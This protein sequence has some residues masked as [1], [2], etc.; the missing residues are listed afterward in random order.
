MSA[1]VSLVGEEIVYFL[2]CPNGLIYVGQTDD[3]AKRRKAHLKGHNSPLAFMP[4]NKD[5][6]RRIHDAFASHRVLREGC[7]S[8]FES[9]ALIPYLERLL[10]R[11]FA[12]LDV[13]D[14]ATMSVAPWLAVAPE[15][16]MAAAPIYVQED[17]FD[18]GRGLLGRL[19]R[20]AKFACYSSETDEWY[21]PPFVIE[22]AR[23]AMGGIDLDPASCFSANRVVQAKHFYSQKIDGLS[24]ANPWFGRVWLNPPY[25]GQAEKFVNRLVDEFKAGRVEQ[26][27]ILPSSQALVTNWCDRAIREASAVGVSRG[28]WEFTPGH[29]QKVSSPAGGSSLLYYGPNSEGFAR[30]FEEIAHVLRP[31]WK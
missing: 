12:T 13:D 2:E 20:N 18:V 17:L 3:W 14:V 16:L 29:G 21:T 30:E 9:A 23:R 5:L 31:L 26:A 6:E 8:E 15:T 11:G 19:R 1:A 10:Q 22:A 24:D 27:V 25:G 7:N 4:G 28:R